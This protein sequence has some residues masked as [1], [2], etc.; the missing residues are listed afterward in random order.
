MG[1]FLIGAGA[2]L[3]PG[4]NASLILQDLPALSV[5]AILAYLAMVLGIA[6]TLRVFSRLMG[7]ARTVS[8][9]GD[10]CSVKKGPRQ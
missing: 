10:F 4:G 6:I 5:H 3:V 8:C 1:G 2:M 7:T 9:G